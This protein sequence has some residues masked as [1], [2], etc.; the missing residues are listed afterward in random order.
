MHARPRAIRY[1]LCWYRVRPEYRADVARLGDRPVL[2]ITRPG[3]SA[4]RIT[5]KSIVA[6]ASAADFAERFNKAAS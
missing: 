3:R 6:V 4:I 1:G 5:L 2:T